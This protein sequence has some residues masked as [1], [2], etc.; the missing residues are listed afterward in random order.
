MTPNA[1][2]RTHARETRAPPLGSAALPHASRKRSH[3][4]LE[5]ARHKRGGYVAGAAPDALHERVDVDRVVTHCV[6]ERVLDVACALF[7]VA[8]TL[9]RVRRPAEL[10]EDVFGGFDELRAVAN[11]PMTT[12]RQRRVYRSWNREDLP[13]LLPGETRG[14]ERARLERC[15]DHQ[16]AARQSRKEAIAA[17]KIFLEGRRARREFRQK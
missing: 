6:E 2:A 8:R 13:A 3:D 17:R 10:R 16:H 15:L 11:Q 7:F 9:D 4:A 1:C 5:L 12:A 14:D